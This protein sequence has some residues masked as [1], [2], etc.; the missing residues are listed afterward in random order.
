MENFKNDRAGGRERNAPEKNQKK[1]IRSLKMEKLIDG[2]RDSLAIGFMNSII[3]NSN[4]IPLNKDRPLKIAER[5]YD[6]A[7]Q[8]IKEMEKQKQEKG[9]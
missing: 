7:D 6:Y 5:A 2:F 3:Q 8:F 1:N 4:C 9:V